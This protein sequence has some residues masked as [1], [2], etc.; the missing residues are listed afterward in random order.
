MEEILPADYYTKS[1]VDCRVDQQV[2]SQYIK[3][4]LPKVHEH[5]KNTGTVS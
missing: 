3:K 5:L 4:K 1:L 2:L